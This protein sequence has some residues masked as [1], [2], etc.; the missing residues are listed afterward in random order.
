MYILES[1]TTL[2]FSPTPRG[3]ATWKLRLEDWASLEGVCQDKFPSL[4]HLHPQ[5]TFMALSAMKGI[6]P[7]VLGCYL[8]WG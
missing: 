8:L 3:A 5:D 2:S 1:F 6:L 4:G 7:S